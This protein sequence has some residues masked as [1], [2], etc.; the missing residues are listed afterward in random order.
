MLATRSARVAAAVD[1]PMARCASMLSSSL[2]ATAFRLSA[3]C[4]LMAVWTE[5]R[6]T[7]IRSNSA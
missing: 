2:A 5:D 3:S 6:T 4:W 7:A 1:R